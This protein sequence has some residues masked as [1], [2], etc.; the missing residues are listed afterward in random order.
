MMDTNKN[1]NPRP[2]SFSLKL[3]KEPKAKGTAARKRAS[4][5]KDKG[6]KV[7]MQKEVNNTMKAHSS[8]VVLDSKNNKAT[9]SK[10][11]KVSMD[12][13]GKAATL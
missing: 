5:V 1:N 12:S 3:T 9:K 10:A 6:R 2:P 11:T 8:K 13:V 4:S 7:E